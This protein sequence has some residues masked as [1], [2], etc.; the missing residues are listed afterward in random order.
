LATR[1]ERSSAEPA[2]LL[3]RRCHHIRAQLD[4]LSLQNYGYTSAH[5]F[6][7]RRWGCVGEAGF[8]L[9]PFYSVGSDF[10][11]TTNTVTVK[12]IRRDRAGRFTEEAVAT[13]FPLSR[14]SSM[15]SGFSSRSTTFSVMPDASAMR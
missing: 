12:V 14:N 1:L 13:A 7:N 5:V 9:D 6:S 15:M 8:F 11:A 10:I 4:F 2:D 3:C